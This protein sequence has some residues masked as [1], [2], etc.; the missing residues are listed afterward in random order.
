MGGR[1]RTDV[2]GAGVGAPAREALVH[3]DDRGTERAGLLEERLTDLPARR[4][5]GRRGT[6]PARRRGSRPSRRRS[7]SAT[8][9]STIW[10]ST[11]S[12]G[13]SLGWASP[14]ISTRWSPHTRS[15]RSIVRAMT[16]GLSGLPANGRADSTIIEV[17]L[18]LKIRSR[19]SVGRVAVVGVVGPARRLGEVRHLGADVVAVVEEVALD[20]EHELVAAD[21]VGCSGGI[22]SGLGRDV[23]RPAGGRRRRRASAWSEAQ[24]ARIVSIDAAPIDDSRKRRRDMPSVRAAPSASRRIRRAV[25]TTSGVGGGGTN[26]PLEHGWSLIGRP[27]STSSSI[28]RWSRRSSRRAPIRPG[29]PLRIAR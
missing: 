27:G 19:N 11:P 25:S 26:S 12:S 4:D 5:R 17:S 20:V 6:S 16:S 14:C 10:V 1:R 2:D 8:Q 13:P 28:A 22:A 29:E 23:E 15:A 24:A 18:R 21:G 3:R 9:R 7:G